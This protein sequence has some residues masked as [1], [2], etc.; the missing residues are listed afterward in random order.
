[1]V[2]YIKTCHYDQLGQKRLIR[3]AKDKIAIWFDNITCT[4]V[5][6]TNGI[7]YNVD[8]ALNDFDQEMD[9]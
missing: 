2:D 7:A 8:M 4:T 1:M 3:F 5:I 9:R 6:L